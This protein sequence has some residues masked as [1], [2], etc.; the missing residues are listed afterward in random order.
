[1]TVGSARWTG[2]HF[3][4]PKTNQRKNTGHIYVLHHFSVTFTDLVYTSLGTQACS[5]YNIFVTGEAMPQRSWQY[6]TG[7]VQYCM[8]K[9]LVI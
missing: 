1:M 8:R 7:Y 3:M 9:H 6:L 5:L 4:Q 2:S